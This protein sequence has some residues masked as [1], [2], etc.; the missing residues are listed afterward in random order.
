MTATK[1]PVEHHFSFQLI[2]TAVFALGKGG[3]LIVLVYGRLGIS[4]LS[5]DDYQKTWE[6][7]LL[8]AISGGL[9]FL[10]PCLVVSKFLNAN[11]R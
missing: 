10:I 2:P 7:I 6:L 5:G 9:M 1:M 11:P 8:E 3:L 4:G